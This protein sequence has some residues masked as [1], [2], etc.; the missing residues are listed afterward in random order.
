[1]RV[2]YLVEYINLPLC[3]LWRDLG[4]A[5]LGTP[6]IIN[7]NRNGVCKTT[8]V[9]RPGFVFSILD[10][11]LIEQPCGFLVLGEKVVAAKLQIVR[12]WH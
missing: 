2:E 11:S 1:M 6:Y 10:Q 8:P 7:D 3:L 5:V 12:Q 4:G 9:L